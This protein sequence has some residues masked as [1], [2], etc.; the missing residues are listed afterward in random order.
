M[1]KNLMMPLGGLSRLELPEEITRRA[2]S[3]EEAQKLLSQDDTKNIYE[4]IKNNQMV[5]N[6][7]DNYASYTFVGALGAIL[8][9]G[10][11][12]WLDGAGFFFWSIFFGLNTGATA[13]LH[14]LAHR[15]HK[16]EML[17]T[18]QLA[19]EE[20]ED[21]LNTYAFLLVDATNYI[22]AQIE[23]WNQSRQPRE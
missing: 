6:R 13:I 17:L 18:R 7:F 2:A 11:S 9:G 19:E 3:Y 10:V 22:N 12:L 5:E 14:K 8:M 15:A 4:R 16:Q 21:K 20:I 1:D 23:L